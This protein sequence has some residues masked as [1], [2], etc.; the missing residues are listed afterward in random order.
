MLKLFYFFLI[1]DF[2]VHFWE[3]KTGQ[4]HGG[5]LQITLS[6]LR[7]FFATGKAPRGH[8]GT[9]GELLGIPWGASGEIWGRFGGQFGVH[10]GVIFGSF[11]GSFF[12]LHF[13]PLI[14]HLLGFR[15]G[16]MRGPK[17]AKTM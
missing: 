1:Y 5:L 9:P 7:H 6:P 14:G 12:E 10:F 13:G 11:F 15:G 8:Q 3:A 16:Q 2:G 17:P 4:K